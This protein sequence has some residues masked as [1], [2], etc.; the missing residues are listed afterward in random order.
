MLAHL[1]AT[2][3]T[4]DYDA[5][6][7]N[8]W[9]EELFS[10]GLENGYRL[11]CY[12]VMRLADAINAKYGKN[13]LSVKLSKNT[14]RELEDEFKDGLDYSKILEPVPQWR[15]ALN[16]IAALS[17]GV[18]TEKREEGDGE[19]R[20][21]WRFS[22]IEY[23]SVNSGS[24]FLRPV[25]QTLSKA[26]KWSKGRS[27]ALKRLAALEV[28][29]MTDIDRQ[30]V[31]KALKSSQYYDRGYPR[32][33]YYIDDSAALPLLAKHPYVFLEDSPGTPVEL[34]EEKPGLK[35]SNSDGQFKLEI[36]PRLKNSTTY[37]IRRESP[38]R[39][40]FTVF[41][42]TIRKIADAMSAS[43]VLTVPKEGVDDLKATIAAVAKVMPV[44]SEVNELRA[45]QAEKTL[46]KA[47]SFS[48][49]HIHL[50]PVAGG[51]RAELFVRPFG[52]DGPYFKPGAG[53]AN[54]VAD[55]AGVA[56]EV[57]RDLKKE[58]SEAKRVIEACPS[59]ATRGDIEDIFYFDSVLECLDLLSEINE[60]I[61]SVAVEW[62]EGGEI[63][64]TN[65][66]SLK[67]MSFGTSS[68]ADWFSLSG[69]LK[70]DEKTVLRLTH[71]I[72]RAGESRFIELDKGRFLALT[73]SLRKKLESVALF[74]DQADGEL[75]IHP[76]NTPLVD[77]LLEDAGKFKR[78]A[79]WRETVK[80]AA[81]LADFNPEVP[82]TL[83]AELRPYQEEGFKWLARLAEWGVGACLADDMGLGKTVQALALVLH[84]AKLGPTL[85]VSPSSVCS[86]W[87][88]ETRKFAPT[89]K[90]ILFREGDRTAILA[91]PKPFEL[92]VTS[93]GLL[94][95]ESD[96]FS[97]VEWS[98]I[99]LDEAQFIKNHKTKR[100]KA[101]MALKGDFKL[102]TTGTPV[103]NH[104][105]ELWTL[106]NFINPG[107]LGTKQRFDERF[108]VPIEK[109]GRNTLR[110]S[111]KKI[112][113]PFILRRLKSAVLEELPPKTEINLLVEMS[114]KER[115][116]YEALRRASV[117]AV[118]TAKRKPGGAAHLRILTELMKLRQACCAPSLI[119]KDADIESSKLKIFGE[120]VDELRENR[121]K[122]LVFS[123]FIGHLAILREYCDA[124]DIQY[125]Y[126]DGSTPPKE[127][128]KRVDAFQSGEG[129]LFLISLKA[130]GT[131]LNLTAAD[132]VIHMDPWWNPAVEDQA[133]DRSHRIG[134]DRPVT[135]YRLIAKN[136]VEEKIV[137]LHKTKRDL[138]NALLDGAEASAKM[139]LDDLV[140]ILR[141]TD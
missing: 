65:T 58:R 74:A 87:I 70:V 140:A 115:A 1:H 17:S 49:I 80:K 124:N 46:K 137:N 59:L 63:S 141:E 129:D 50:L 41:D 47:K 11:L 15:S 122:A 67:D 30:I 19:S 12:Q 10:T 45:T 99:V 98:N 2:G 103:E 106:F 42:S 60:I 111:L 21:T 90:P 3:R 62:P 77:A 40:V 37:L 29:S 64:L 128:S 24:I 134:Q 127:R 18:K 83:N 13:K 76:L 28:D 79:K 132:Y 4:L 20:L 138:A 121:H 109:E 89:L 114:E 5:S 6:W 85:V 126:L 68:G 26:G 95:S 135:V 86:N 14:R 23:R 66:Y 116:F 52:S 55:I 96:A 33:D 130:G 54:V 133:S 57:A 81:E 16:K 82:S 104:L 61:D 102:I 100:A 91:G 32:V 51:M 38:S 53:G 8:E 136:T 56:T 39:F 72:E 35:V 94:A 93:Y 88:S 125:Q 43:G 92:I 31:K 75:R 84:R 117:E 110:N 25:E 71:L 7:F 101:A 48:K 120:I 97:K 139:S 131:G 105:D 27:V 108:A 9:F 113:Q 123:Q 118:E 107:L 44:N 112:I 36:Y 69:D 78:N 22:C 34:V 73:E 119:S